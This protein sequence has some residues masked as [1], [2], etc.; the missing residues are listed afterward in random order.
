LIKLHFKIYGH[1][2]IEYETLDGVVSKYAE[3]K[4]KDSIIVSANV[5]DTSITPNKLE[6]VISS[7]DVS[8]TLNILFAKFDKNKANNF[9]INGLLRN[10]IPKTVYGYECGDIISSC[11]VSILITNPYTYVI[12]KNV[13]NYQFNHIEI[14]N[15]FTFNVTKRW[16]R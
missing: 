8:E 3:E 7:S 15:D 12:P 10:I 5:Y 11:E 4:Y 9:K 14:N 1:Q 16:G 13:K 6:M 2:I